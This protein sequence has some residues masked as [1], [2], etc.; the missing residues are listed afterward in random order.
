[1]QTEIDRLRK[2]VLKLQADKDSSMVY[3]ASLGFRNLSDVTGWLTT[4]VGGAKLGLI[5]D[6]YTL[7][8]SV[9][10][11]LFGE[12]EYFKKL[13]A[14]SKLDLDSVREATALV[15]FSSPVPDLFTEPGRGSYGRNE[16]AFSRYPTVKK[17]RELGH[18]KNIELLPSNKS[19]MLR[20]VED[21]VVPGDPRTVIV[22]AITE[23]VASPESFCAYLPSTHKSLTNTVC[24]S[25]RRG[26]LPRVLASLTFGSSPPCE[27]A[28]LTASRSKP[29]CSYLRWS[30]TEP[31][32][33]ST[34]WQ[35]SHVTA[36]KITR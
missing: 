5:T 19:G 12:K 22:L 32:R 13:E 34:S 33:L 11:E 8:L 7:S 27:W 15:A 31:L 1:M 35:N 29:S 2:D 24:L 20:G 21:L 9:S 23:Y 16:S 18:D 25:T 17:W 6:I 4:T 10:K 30:G 28:K 14:V 3:F 36:I 26:A